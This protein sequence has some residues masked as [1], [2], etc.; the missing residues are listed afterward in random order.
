MSSRPLL[1]DQM[2]DADVARTLRQ[3]GYD[4]VRTSEVGMARADDE[5][6]LDRAVREGRIIV[7]LDEDFGDWAVLPLSKH[8]G[9]IRI[10][11][12]VATTTQILAVLLPFL[13]E[14]VHRV[15]RDR[16][17]IVRKDSVRWIDT[18]SN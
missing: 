15:F 5:E 17:V 13:G 16:L 11:V 4:V 12:C 3:R 9:V 1:L 8:P 2:L 6:I 7:T 14:S 10:K 18:H